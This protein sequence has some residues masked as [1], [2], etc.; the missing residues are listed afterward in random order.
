[1]KEICVMKA[2]A[3]VPPPQPEDHYRSTASFHTGAMGRPEQGNHLS[4]HFARDHT[5]LP[6]AMPSQTSLNVWTLSNGR[7]YVLIASVT[8]ELANTSQRVAVNV[9]RSDTTLVCAKEH[10][11]LRLQPLIVILRNP[12]QNSHLL[13]LKP[14][15]I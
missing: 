4:A 15:R 3:C 7:S 6:N 2:G 9:A 11:T 12:L 14:R 13:L 5:Q 8:T 10:L 1:M